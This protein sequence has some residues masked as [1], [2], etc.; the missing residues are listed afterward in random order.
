MDRRVASL[1]VA[2]LLAASLPGCG[3]GGLPTAPVRGKVTFMGKPLTAGTILYMPEGDKPS[4]TSEIKPDG[5]YV[6]T[7]YT[8]NDGAVLGKHTILITA[9]EDQSDRLPEDRSPTPG[10]LIPER[11]NNFGTSGL[12]ADVKAGDNVFDFELT[13]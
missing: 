3:T 4:A 11:Y 2:L 10:L 1:L 5:T 7:T 8:A 9:I 6:L 12:T 13:K